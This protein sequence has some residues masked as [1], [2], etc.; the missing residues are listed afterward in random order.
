MPGT[1]STVLCVGGACY[2]HGLDLALSREKAAWAKLLADHNATIAE[3]RAVEDFVRA[4][5]LADYTAAL[6]AAAPADTL[7]AAF[8]AAQ[9]ERGFVRAK[10]LADHTAGLAAATTSTPALCGLGYAFC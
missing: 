4:K 5:A 1:L 10:A 3:K 6:A 8:A 9:A 7:A 2:K